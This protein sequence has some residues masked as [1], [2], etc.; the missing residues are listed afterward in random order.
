MIP[1]ERELSSLFIAT[2]IVMGAFGGLLSSAMTML[3]DP[4]CPE[5]LKIE[6]AFFSIIV[7]MVVIGRRFFLEEVYQGVVL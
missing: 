1:T 7:G 2:F 6:I 3:V 4:A 5:I